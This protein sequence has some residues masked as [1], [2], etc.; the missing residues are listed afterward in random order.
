MYSI[1]TDCQA[2]KKPSASAIGTV[3]APPTRLI[4]GDCAIEWRF[5]FAIAAHARLIALARSSN[6]PDLGFSLIRLGRLL[7]HSSGSDRRGQ[8]LPSRSGAGFRAGYQPA[9]YLARSNGGCRAAGENSIDRPAG[10]TVSPAR[11]AAGAGSYGRSSQ[12]APYSLARG[13]QRSVTLL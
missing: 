11:C 9:M 6:S 4:E 2:P 10:R 5:G 13:S 8:R 7:T 12:R 3:P 1:D